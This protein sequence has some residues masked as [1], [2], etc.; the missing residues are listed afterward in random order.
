MQLTWHGHVRFHSMCTSARPG[1]L[2]FLPLHCG[3]VP[4]TEAQQRARFPWTTFERCPTILSLRRRIL[5]AREATRTLRC[6]RVVATPHSVCTVICTTGVGAHVRGVAIQARIPQSCSP[7]TS[8]FDDSAA[9]VPVIQFGPR[10]GQT[11]TGVL[12]ACVTPGQGAVSAAAARRPGLSAQLVGAGCWFQPGTS[13]HARSPVHSTCRACAQVLAPSIE[14]GAVVHCALDALLPPPNPPP[15][16]PS[17]AS[18][19]CR[20]LSTC[21]PFAPHGCVAARATADNGA[22]G[23]RALAHADA[24]RSAIRAGA[25]PLV[26]RL[27]HLR[28]SVDLGHSCSQQAVHSQPYARL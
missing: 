9:H 3:G 18:C 26:H 22:A 13:A 10:V 21:R 15:T 6:P 16:P 4:Q 20:Q 5:H 7:C 25:K 1:L 24:G 14:P 19:R 8:S 12:G 28:R 27:S 2:H 11:A 23:L 17:F